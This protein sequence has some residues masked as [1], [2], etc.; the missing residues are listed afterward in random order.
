MDT[1]HRHFQNN[2]G[3]QDLLLQNVI[4]NNMVSKEFVSTCNI[5]RK[6]EELDFRY[7]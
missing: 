2:V 7:S 4:V 3:K 5:C 1:V 6:F